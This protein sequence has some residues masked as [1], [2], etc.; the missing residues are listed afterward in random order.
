VR[1]VT[2]T[3]AFARW[4]AGSKAVTDEGNPKVL[5]HATASSSN[6]FYCGQG[7]VGREYGEDFGTGFYFFSRADTALTYG[8]PP[9]QDIGDFAIRLVPVYLCAVNPPVLRSVKDLK[10]FWA[11]SGGKE[12][13]FARTAQEK[14]AHILGLGFDSVLACRYAQWVVYQ[15]AQIKAAIDDCAVSDSI[16]TNLLNSITDSNDQIRME[17]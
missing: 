3:D 7:P 13:W 10:A 17:R 6:D 1:P 2:Q 11:R 15:P 4:F 12:A 16:M 9:S 14:A 8:S 5:F